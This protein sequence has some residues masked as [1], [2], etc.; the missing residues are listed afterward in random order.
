[1]LGGPRRS[2]AATLRAGAL[3]GWLGTTATLWPGQAVLPVTEVPRAVLDGFRTPGVSPWPTPTGTGSNTNTAARDVATRN[4]KSGQHTKN[5]WK[6]PLPPAQKT[7]SKYKNFLFQ[8]HFYRV[9]ES[10]SVPGYQ[11]KHQTYRAILN[12]PAAGPI[13]SLKAMPALAEQVTN[14]TTSTRIQGNWMQRKKK[15]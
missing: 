6:A 3:G 2:A 8:L 9:E 1:M 5:N 15:N 14:P 13:R 4:Q 11:H 12:T 7:V 10:Q